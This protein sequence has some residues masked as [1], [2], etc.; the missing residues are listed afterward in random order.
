[1]ARDWDACG[2]APYRFLASNGSISPYVR[3]T[4]DDKGCVGTV[5]HLNDATGNLAKTMR[6]LHVKNVTGTS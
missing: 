4:Y 5:S 3:Y 1:M 2:A 6:P